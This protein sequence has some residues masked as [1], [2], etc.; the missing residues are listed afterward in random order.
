MR[1]CRFVRNKSTIIFSVLVLGFS[2]YMKLSPAK[3]NNF[4]D[5]MSAALSF[6]SLAT[7]LFFSYFSL[8]PA[9][10]NSKFI[11][12]LQE[13]GTDKKI[14]DRLLLSTIIFFISSIL[15]FGQLFFSE[16]TNNM[17]SI[18]TTAVW[19]SF[20]LSGFFNTFLILAIVLKAFEHYA[21]TEEN[22]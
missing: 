14:M 9:F 22:D 4:T 20:T 1:R 17:F 7:A 5:I 12:A 18:I 13:L 11:I 3:F 16:C 2:F 21:N 19:L 8:I 10:S 15:S 6:S